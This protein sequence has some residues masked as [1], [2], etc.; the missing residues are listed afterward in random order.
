[1]SQWPLLFELRPG[2]YPLQLDQ[3]NILPA[4]AGPACQA[5]AGAKFRA[6]GGTTRN[7]VE[8]TRDLALQSLFRAMAG[9]TGTLTY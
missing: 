8:S 2:L 4:S 9:L 7:W 1:M 6:G 5:S 3:H